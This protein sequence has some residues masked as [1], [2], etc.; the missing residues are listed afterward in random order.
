MYCTNCGSNV[1]NGLFCGDC[2]TKV[3]KDVPSSIKRYNIKD[4]LDRMIS[5]YYEKYYGGKRIMEADKYLTKTKPLQKVRWSSFLIPMILLFIPYGAAGLL[6]G[7]IL[8]VPIYIFRCTSKN[9]KE[10]K[11][12]F[13]N[14]SLGNIN[15][16]YMM[17][18]NN[19]KIDDIEIIDYTEN[20]INIVFKNSTKHRIVSDNN[21]YYIE[22][23]GATGKQFV[24]SGFTH[25]PA[26]MFRNS[27]YVNPILLA[28]IECYLENKE[29]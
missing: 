4:Y 26:V 29:G 28:Y 11:S 5:R 24:K 15:D 2:G 19:L 27:V 8:G 3:E 23:V 1:L 14:E 13:R 17:L 18:L 22:C 7:A 12:T 25:S 20:T 16:L 21:S 10:N 9:I 6:F